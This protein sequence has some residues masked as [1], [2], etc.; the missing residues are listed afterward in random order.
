LRGVQD[1]QP[2]LSRRY[3]VAEAR[4]SPSRAQHTERYE[5]Q[6][7]GRRIR[8]E[9]PHGAARGTGRLF[10]DDEE[11]EVEASESGVIA[12]NDMAFKEYGS[13]EELAEDIIRQRGT[14]EIKRGEGKHPHH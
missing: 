1:L 6:Y 5:T 14:A 9:T 13:L 2:P 7:R 4:R 10:I 12:H 8:I 11:V 3:T